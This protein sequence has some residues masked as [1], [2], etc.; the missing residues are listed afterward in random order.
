M[1]LILWEIVLLRLLI[2]FSIPSVWSVYTLVEHHT[3]AEIKDA[4]MTE[5]ESESTMM[6]GDIAGEKTEIEK[7]RTDNTIPVWG[8]IWLFGAVASAGYFIV[9][10]VKG[11][12]EFAMS[13]PVTNDFA[14]KWIEEQRLWRKIVIR[15]SDQVLTPLT[16]GMCSPVI[17]LP[18]GMDW[19]DTEKLHY[20]LMHEYEIGRAHV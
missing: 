13:L 17:L 15:Q 7:R 4:V 10:Y 14:R 11:Y 19:E 9:L 6:F 1:F 5:P 16:Y 2:P 20:I 8:I 3:A 18:K 12:R